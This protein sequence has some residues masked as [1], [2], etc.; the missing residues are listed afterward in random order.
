[1]KAAILKALRAPLGSVECLQSS[2][3]RERAVKK[4]VEH[5]SGAIHESLLHR[6]RHPQHV[7]AVEAAV[8]TGE[9]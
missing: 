3:V 6:Q 2:A 4:G 8:L 5:T 9:I 7:G 1:M